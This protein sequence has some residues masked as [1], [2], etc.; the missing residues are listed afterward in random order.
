M[1]KLKL[2]FNG[3]LFL[4]LAQAQSLKPQNGVTPTPPMGW[5]SYNCYGATVEESE[6][7]ANAQYLAKNMKQ[8]GW[9]YVVIDFCWF[10]PHPPGSHQDNPPQYK[11]PKGGLVP[12]MPMDKFGRLLPDPRKFPSSAGGK[13]FKPLADYV[14]SLG[15][16]FGIH[17]MRGIPRQ[18]YWAKT[19]IMGTQGI[20][21]EMV[22]D[23]NSKCPWLNSMWG[24]DMTK[25]GG[26]EYYNSI[27]KLYAEWGVDYVKVD[28]TDLDEKYPYRRAEVEAIRKAIA[29]CGRP[30]V[31]SLSLNMKWDNREHAVANAE[32]WRISKDFWDSWEQV[33]EQFELC[34]KW[35]T[36][37]QKNAYPDADML[38]IGKIAKRGPVGAER[39]SRL[40]EDELYTHISLW[41][42]A[43]SPLM[44]GGNLPENT[45]FVV[46]LLTNPEVL[47]VNQKGIEAKQ[48]YRKDEICVWVSKMPNSKD[49]NLAIFNLSKEGKDI[50]ISWEELG[51]KGNC[52]VR[53]LWAKQDLGS[54]T[55]Q[56]NM[57]VNSHGAKLFKMTPSVK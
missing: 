12:W 42:I 29:Q 45:P 52:K 51:L 37:T 2:T 15:L 55:G 53:D 17:V 46:N 33:E 16:K 10:Y 56:F 39:Y 50:K 40:T 14:H 36:V 48:L 4:F 30:I 22:A 13:G 57:M 49:L 20:T 35:A 26:Q 28:D 18:A 25:G 5:N 38:Q 31:L 1:K 8:F 21:A 44:M 27:F 23:T 47:A 9:Q 11:L 19:P 24:V 54:F 3:L 7:K 43:R 41:S 6:V 34:A 32:L